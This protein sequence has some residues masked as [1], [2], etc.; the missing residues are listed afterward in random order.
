MKHYTSE[1]KSSR[2]DHPQTLTE[3][4]VKPHYPRNEISVYIITTVWVKP[5]CMLARTQ[6]ESRPHRR[7]IRSPPPIQKN[8]AFQNHDRVLHFVKLFVSIKSKNLQPPT[9]HWIAITET[10]TG[11]IIPIQFIEKRDLLPDTLVGVPCDD[12]ERSQEEKNIHFVFL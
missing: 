2:I 8:M 12:E 10:Q 3:G 1:S 7:Q 11:F 4:H 6:N 9:I 5:I